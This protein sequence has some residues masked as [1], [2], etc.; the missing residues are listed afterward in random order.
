VR[1]QSAFLNDVPRG[2]DRSEQ[3]VLYPRQACSAIADAAALLSV[4]ATM[5]VAK[6]HRHRL[7]WRC[8]THGRRGAARRRGAP[9]CR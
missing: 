8:I 7:N 6:H 5:V 4:D 1:F 2:M 3:R 9:R